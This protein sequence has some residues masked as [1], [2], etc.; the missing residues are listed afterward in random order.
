MNRLMLCSGQTRREGWVTLDSNSAHDPVILVSIPPLPSQVTRVKW[1]E[2]ELIHGITSFYPWEAA[3]LLK[4]IHGVL[5]PGGK[6]VLEQPDL[7]IV[8]RHLYFGSASPAW[9]FGDPKLLNPAH[10]NK[11]AYS[12]DS[13]H[14]ALLSAGFKRIE[15]KDALHHNPVRDFRMEAYK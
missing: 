15:L 4:E 5:A 1:D 9:L 8:V 7:T 2:I 13:L 3:Q 11:W 6:L 14:Q 12:Q 10:M